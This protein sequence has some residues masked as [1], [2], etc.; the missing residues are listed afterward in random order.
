MRSLDSSRKRHC[1]TRG[2]S[3][4]VCSEEKKGIQGTLYDF[5]P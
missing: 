1:C 5:L 2:V 3:Q 4:L